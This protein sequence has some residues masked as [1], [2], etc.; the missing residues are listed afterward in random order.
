MLH[1]F[2][3]QACY[4]L[5]AAVF[6]VPL[7]NYLGLSSVIGFLIAGVAIGPYGLS[8]MGDVKEIFR[9]AEL[10]VVLLLFVIG[11]EIHPEKMMRLR[12]SVFLLGGSQVG[13]TS[14]L[15][16][17]VFL[18]LGH[19]PGISLL[20][21]IAFSL[22]STAFVLNLLEDENE[23]QFSSGQSAFGILL[24]QDLVVIPLLAIVPI[25][26]AASSAEIGMTWTKFA[27]GAVAVIALISLGHFLLKPIFRI[28][29]KNGE[30]EI[31]TAASL[32]TVA[33]TALFIESIGLSMG[34]GALIAGMLLA[35]FEHRT[36]IE[37]VMSPF[38]GMLM[39]LFF[40]AVGMSINFNLVA[41]KIDQVLFVALL[42]M[43][44]KGLL[45]YGLFKAEGYSRHISRR[46]GILLCQGGE[47]GIYILSSAQLHNIMEESVADLFIA[48][49]TLS[50]A[51]N[52]LFL[53]IYD[54][55][56]KFR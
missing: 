42:F 17:G 15:L 19:A 28:L 53:F 44:I 8:L 38:K 45:I 32:L 49:L 33:S 11:L 7:S 22:S 41:E 26:G 14:L 34:L 52:P 16:T 12:R 56:T 1:D 9:F 37:D 18:L 35:G 30:R 13:L 46:M 39:G 2:L 10:G 47:F 20:M 4:F 24:L 51:M 29:I 21:G 5:S 23:L 48:T 25:I 50:M 54:K 6:F 40:M 36:E 55:V 3:L 31:T 27:K 43:L